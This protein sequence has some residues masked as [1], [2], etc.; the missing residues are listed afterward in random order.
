[1]AFKTTSLDEIMIIITGINER[2]QRW[3]GSKNSAHGLFN[4]RK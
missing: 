3:K 1:M 2:G 4:I